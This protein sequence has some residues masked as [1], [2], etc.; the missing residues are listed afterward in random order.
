MCPAPQEDDRL[1]LAH[2][3][4]MAE[5]CLVRGRPVFSSF[6]DER[7]QQLAVSRLSASR[8]VELLLWGGFEGAERRCAGVFCSLPEPETFDITAITAEYR[9]S[10]SLTHRDFLGTIM[11]LG[12]KRES[13]GDILV[14]AGRCVFFVK[15]D[16]SA[17]LLAQLDK[18]GGVGLRLSQGFSGELPAA[19]HFESVRATVASARLDCVVKALLGSSRETSAEL[20]VSGRVTHGFI[21][22]KSVSAPVQEG[23]RISVQGYGKFIIDSIGS[24]N[25]KGRLPLEARRYV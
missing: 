7:Q 19:H 2:L 16:I 10:E 12:I 15:N 18:A 1:L 24:P 13:V 8:S 17:Y 14:E 11:S 20:I 5:L 25:R 6:L 3:D 22:Q 4:D 9:K 23:D 21:K